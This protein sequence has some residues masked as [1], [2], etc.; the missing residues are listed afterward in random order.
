MPGRPREH[1]LEEES[2]I[3]LRALLP[4]EW[5]LET[6]R[7]DYGLDA[8]V[9]VFQDGRATGLAFWGQLKATDEPDLRRALK[10]GFETTSLNYLSVQADPVLLVRYHAP[11]RRLFGTWLH[12]HDIRLKRAGQ[13]TATVRWR[14]PEE[15]G[16]GSPD[17]LADEVRRH[18]RIGSPASLPLTV[19][20]DTLRSTETLRASVLAL[21]RTTLVAAGAHLTLVAGPPADLRMTIGPKVIKVDTPLST[22][23]AETELSDQPL[24]VADDAAA[25][26][27]VALGGLGLPAAAVDL[28]LRCSGARLLRSD[29]T[30]GRLAQAFG[31]AGRWRD[32]S[33]LSL[34]CLT[35]PP[36]RELLGRLLDVGVLMADREPS[37]A[38]ARHIAANLIELARRQHAAGEN[39]G[40]AYYSAGNWLFHTVRDYPAALRAY[41]AAAEARPDYR[42]QDYWLQETAAALFETADYAAA[43]AMYRQARA[44]ANGP[45]AGLLARTADCLAHAGDTEHALLLLVRYQRC[46]P[47]PE[48]PWILKLLALRQLNGAAGTDGT[49]VEE[50][51]VR[52]EQHANE[53]AEGAEEPWH[54]WPSLVHPGLGVAADL[55]RINRA[56]ARGDAAAFLAVLTA[57]CAFPAPDEPEP[58][59][60]LLLLAWAL[61]QSYGADWSLPGDVLDAA[62]NTA[63]HRRGDALLRDLLATGGDM[64]A[65]LLAEV[66]DRVAKAAARDKRVLV[67]AVHDDGRRDTLEIGLGVQRH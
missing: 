11:T 14:L 9:E 6:V 15:L 58:W 63:V 8:R 32:A 55:E 30:A 46:E 10:V 59:A 66:E 56:A 65:G 27:A 22:L 34:D 40:A 4:A 48:S 54:D 7:R 18:R 62:L 60:A 23:R 20:V 33:D 3:A 16:P 25:A 29:D 1:V 19:H 28:A 67:R 49:T 21:L 36:G 24:A 5:T 41:E 12:R 47:H 31:A 64:P 26:L 13:K 39:P 45:A 44:A 37:E 17:A 61:G 51:A 43:A 38:D 50:P 2:V 35:G 52:A 53:D 42:T 57:G